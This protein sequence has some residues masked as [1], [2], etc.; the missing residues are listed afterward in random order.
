[1]S[2]DLPI[3]I[4]E[5]SQT[6]TVL[7]M[8]S[9]GTVQM[10]QYGV[11]GWGVAVTKDFQPLGPTVLADI[12]A[13]VVDDSIVVRPTLVSCEIQTWSPETIARIKKFEPRIL[14]L[15]C[16]FSE[17]DP[18]TIEAAA[19]S[20]VNM[21]LIVL[22]THWR[23]DN[24]QR[25]VYLNRIDYMTSLQPPEWPRLSF[26]GLTDARQA[27]AVIRIGRLHAG[28]EQRIAQL[29]ISEAL[30]GEHIARLEKALIAAQQSP[31]FK[32]PL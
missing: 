13:Q 4:S 29:R 9:T 6:P 31:H 18:K 14:K 25:L 19:Q 12:P 17:V 11:A 26:I 28:H 10:K 23:D 15:N 3:I 22:G 5:E 27:E 21:G 24:T 16:A 32:S 8:S 20:I 2:D 7:F 30:R 1:M